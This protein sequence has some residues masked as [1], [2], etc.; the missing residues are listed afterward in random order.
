M[1]V[2]V[3]AQRADASVRRAGRAVHVISGHATHAVMS[4]A[5][6]WMENANASLAGKVNT[7]P[8]VSLQKS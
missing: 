6:V 8:L 1:E 3:F 2:M 5:S 4:T 7:A